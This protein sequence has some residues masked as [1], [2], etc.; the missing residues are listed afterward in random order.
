M[1][2]QMTNPMQFR[3]MNAS[4]HAMLA[5]QNAMMKVHCGADGGVHGGGGV[6]VYHGGAGNMFGGN[7]MVMPMQQMPPMLIQPM[8]HVS[9]QKQNQQHQQNHQPPISSLI[10]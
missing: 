8:Q 3:G 7:G 9:L 5:H 1:G 4:Q 10:I 2:L 6:S